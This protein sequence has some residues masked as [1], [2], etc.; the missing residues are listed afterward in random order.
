MTPQEL[1]EL[2]LG[3]R[4][5]LNLDPE[6][7]PNPTYDYGTVTVGGTIVHIVWDAQHECP[8]FSDPVESVLDTKSKAW[9]EFISFIEPV[10]SLSTAEE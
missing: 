10:S 5:R 2:H 9:N 8:P 3:T 4:V 6:D 1:S 7:E